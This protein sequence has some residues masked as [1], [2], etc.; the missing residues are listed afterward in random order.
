MT[1]LSEI[2]QDKK[3]LSLIESIVKKQ[4]QHFERS[5]GWDKHVSWE[6]LVYEI[7]KKGTRIRWKQLI[8]KFKEF[9]KIGYPN[10]NY[11]PDYDK[12]ESDDSDDE[13]RD[14]ALFTFEDQVD[15]M[16]KGQNKRK[17]NIPK[18]IADAFV[19]FII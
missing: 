13:Q 9:S 4:V 18:E 7:Y 12:N 1:G 5:Y 17:E 11:D 16:L 3:E 6:K 14:V 19:E 8:N 15:D 2:Q 10:P